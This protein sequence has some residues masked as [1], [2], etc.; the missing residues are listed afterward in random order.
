MTLTIGKTF[1]PINL[2]IVSFLLI[3]KINAPRIV[4]EFI[5]MVIIKKIISTHVDPEGSLR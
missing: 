3:S 5:E 1:T 2:I 4:P